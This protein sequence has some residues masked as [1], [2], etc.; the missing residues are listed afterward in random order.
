MSGGVYGG[1]EVGAIV[2][3]IGAHS[4]RAGY[5]G[6]DCPKY[7]IPTH[8][9][10]LEEEVRDEIMETEGP[11]EE[12]PK[13]PEKKFYIDTNYIHLPKENMEIINPVKD[14][15]IEDW[16]TFEK[17]LDYMYAKDIK[18]ESALHPVVMSEASWN[19]R[20]K[21]EKLTEL[22]F[23][24]YNIPAFFLCKSAVLTAFANGRSTGLVIDSGA[25]QTSAV[26][27]HDG[28]VLQQ[29]IVKSPL[30]GDFITAQCRQMFEE[31]TIEI[32]PPYLIASK[33][34]SKE[35][36][37]A[38]F[39]KKNNIP[40]LTKSFHRHMVNETIQDFQASVLQVSDG[41]YDESILGNIPGVVYEFPNGYNNTFGV[42]RFKICEGLFD[43]SNVKGI[44]GSTA[45]GVTQVV[46]TSV[47]MTDIDI[48]AGLFGSVI[49]TGGNTLLQGFTDRLNR[50][51][52]SKTPPSMRLKLISSA[53]TER[54]FNPWIGGSI[55]ASL[56]SFQQMWI[57]KQEYEDQGKGC[58][59]RKC[60]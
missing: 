13:L 14:G 48:R 24:K 20:A 28:Y 53:P 38:V 43:P 3:D 31:Q 58:V 6:E 5:A 35:G 12:K 22:M 34:T 41:P 18:S 37:P 29:A 21:R 54:R 10:T 46:T 55:L 30:A 11:P 8:V 4:V 32:V 44:E 17:L 33:E 50:E 52:L 47:G 60:P 45:I 1:D 39:T 57:S 25:T 19:V 15:M 23:E 42:E 40:P 2:F 9:G 56:G 36:G 16:D 27:V 7:D 49:V 26:P 59:E 51:L